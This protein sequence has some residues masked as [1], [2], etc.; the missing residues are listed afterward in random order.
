MSMCL[1]VIYIHYAKSSKEKTGNIITLA[2]FEDGDLVSE[3]SD[4]AEIGDK[5]DDDSVITP[6]LSKAEIDTM[7]CVN[8]SD[9]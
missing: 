9:D 7:D 6:L 8:E 3:T 1:S 4:N 5:S 2:Q